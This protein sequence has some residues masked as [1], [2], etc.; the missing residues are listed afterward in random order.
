MNS[1]EMV[2]QNLINYLNYEILLKNKNM[3]SKD[4]MIF[5]NME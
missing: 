4:F 3:L 2:L 5:S 1:Y